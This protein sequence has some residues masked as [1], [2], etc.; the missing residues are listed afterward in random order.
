[1]STKGSLAT[2][3]YTEAAVHMAREHRD[4]V[5][6]FIAQRRMENVGV[7]MP[8]GVEFRRAVQARNFPLHSATSQAN[9]ARSNDITISKSIAQVITGDVSEARSTLHCD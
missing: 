3:T 6:G 2:G 8:M 4:F 1:M 7:E 9:C 5:V